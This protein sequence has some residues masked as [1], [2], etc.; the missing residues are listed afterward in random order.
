M[1]AIFGFLTRG[2]D[3]ESVYT[4]HRY[5]QKE[6]EILSNHDS[7]DYLPGHS[8]VYKEWLRRQPARL[9]WDRW[10]MMGLI[11]V[12]IGVVYFLLHQ[13]IHLMSHFKWHKAEH[14]L[15]DGLLKTWGWVLGFSVFFASIS[16]ASVAFLCL[17][18]GGSGIPE[19]IGF[20]NGTVMRH[21]LNLRAFCIK[22]F[23]C[24]CAVGA[25]LPVGP[26][27]PMIHMGAIVGTG[28]SQFRSR[29]LGITLPFFTRFRNS[30]DRRNFTTAGAAAGVAAAFGAPVGGLLFA[31]EEVS[32]FWSMK[33][34]WMI[35]FSCMLATFTADLFN[36]SFEAFHFSGWFGLF[37]TDKYIIFKLGNAIPVNV[38]MFAPAMLLGF[39]GGIFGAIF[40]ILNLKITRLRRR[41]VSR[42]KPPFAQKIVR[43]MEPPIIMII[44]ATITIFLPLAF[45]CKPMV[46]S[47]ESNSSMLIQLKDVNSNDHHISDNGHHMQDDAY[48]IDV[49]H[50]P[51]ET[52]HS[53]SYCP[54]NDQKYVID[55]QVKTFLCQA[56]V[57][58]NGTIVSG[59]YNEVASLLHS[60]VQSALRLLFSRRT[61]LQFN[62]ESLLAVLP[63]FFIL[64]CW[65]S[66]SA[67]SSGIVVPMLFIGGIYGRVIGRVL[68]DLH[69][70]VPTDH[71]WRW[72][73]PGALALIGAASF[74]GGV[75]R[76]TMSLT[77]IMI[78]ITNDVAFLLPIMVAIM[79]S[80]WVGD[81]ITHPLYHSLLEL[82]CIPFLDSEPIVYDEQHKLLNL[83]LFKAR[84]VMHCP[85]ITIT[86]R[87]SAAHL[88][89]LLLETTHGGFPVVKWH[90]DVKQEVAYGLLT[91]T[92]I[93]AIL[94]GEKLQQQKD[95]GVTLTPDLSYEDVSVDRI[96]ASVNLVEV[97][98]KY[99]ALP[100]YKEVYINLEPYVN[101][102][103][104]HIEEDFALHRTYIIFR[105]MGL[106]HLTVVD[107]ANRV[108]GLISRKDLMGFNLEEKLEQRKRRGFSLDGGIQ[109]LLPSELADCS[110]RGWGGDGC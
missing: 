23:S 93:A 33:L 51:P 41:L 85:V 34:G 60:D 70:G 18:A 91:R 56:P 9:D 8:V 32:S 10:I 52:L 36:S 58:V 68:V 72:I 81:Y 103:A 28:L 64:A 2:R 108:V 90:D 95:S 62:Y 78:E 102:S 107:T 45:P 44:Y 26:E 29:T 4:N 88:S 89:H 106:R 76:L 37:H 48:H 63:I 66:G 19:V 25:G 13:P 99:T 30:E 11:G 86:S 79:V 17:T 5:T 38:I 50:S 96:P 20:L 84:D 75:S 15:H 100:H 69:G 47:P 65:A 97:L 110:S 31:M 24:C 83:E 98:E 74:F 27:G 61:H 71:F 59:E 77:V 55:E 80:K 101:R 7:F 82:K 73:D 16:S 14:L 92:E 39:I 1:I 43:F 42:I 35:F 105:T 109:K 49:P 6:R 22:F 57:K 54:P 21:V 40:T 94:L 87:E 53:K 104:P 12:S 3:F 67:V 46:C